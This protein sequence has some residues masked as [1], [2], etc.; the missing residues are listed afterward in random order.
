[1]IPEPKLENFDVTDFEIHSSILNRANS[2]IFCLRSKNN[3]FVEPQS[4]SVESDRPLIQYQGS[5]SESRILQAN[6]E[7]FCLALVCTND[8]DW[9][10]MHQLIN[11]HS[12]L[13]PTRRQ[14]NQQSNDNLLNAGTEYL[15]NHFPKISNFNSR[16]NSA[17]N[18]K[19]E[20]NTVR[21]SD[22]PYYLTDWREV[23][24]TNEMKKIFPNTNDSAKVFICELPIGFQPINLYNLAIQHVEDQKGFSLDTRL[25][26]MAELAEVVEHIEED[27]PFSILKD[28]NHNGLEMNPRLVLINEAF[29]NQGMNTDN[30][31]KIKLILYPEI[32]SETNYDEGG[33]G[34]PRIYK[35]TAECEKT[36]QQIILRNIEL[37]LQTKFI[38]KLKHMIGITAQLHDDQISPILKDHPFLQLVNVD[39]NQTIFLTDL[40]PDLIAG[41][42]ISEYLFIRPSYRFGLAKNRHKFLDTF[43]T[44]LWQGRK[45]KSGQFYKIKLNE[46]IKKIISDGVNYLS[47]SSCD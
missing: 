31:N 39:E 2:N 46:A 5:P 3:N 26:I 7:K 10:L 19:L 13:Y 47:D 27:F 22:L 15:K 1:M 28:L 30:K 32:I 29:L 41:E 9:T 38:E 12:F 45:M 34:D 40:K 43:D 17:T 37:N 25:Q 6:Q 14:S 21:N 4:N 16:K 8:S 33:I 35:M 44:I 20:Y 23:V 24:F 11:V 42:Q 18:G 36:S